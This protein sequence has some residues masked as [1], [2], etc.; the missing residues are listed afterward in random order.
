MG[1]NSY[2]DSTLQSPLLK[3]KPEKLYCTC[4]FLT[5][6]A[7]SKHNSSVP[8]WMPAVWAGRLDSLYVRERTT[9]AS[10]VHFLCS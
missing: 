3:G 10:A 1:G 6:Y 2:L 5:L 8:V 7:V 4:C 9:A